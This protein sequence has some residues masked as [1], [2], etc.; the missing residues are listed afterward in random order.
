MWHKA[1]PAVG[2]ALFGVSLWVLARELDRIGFAGL[3]TSLAATPRAALL[4]ALAVTALN[5]FV[6]T[7]HDQLAFVYARVRLHRARIALAS[8][9]GY[10]VANNVGFALLSGASARYRFYSRWGVTPGELSRIVTFYSTTFWLGLC[11]MGGSSLVFARDAALAAIL[12]PF[13]TTGLGVL[14]LAVVG[15]YLIVCVRDAGPLR[16][17]GL[18]IA[19]P[20]RRLV[21]AQVLVSTLDWLLAAGVLYVLLPAPRPSLLLVTGAFAAAQ[22]VALASHVPG[23]L[24]VFEGVML[25]LLGDDVGTAP[26]ATA[27]LLFRVIYYLVPLVAAIIALLV[28]EGRQRRRQLT[29]WGATCEAVAS[30]AAPRILAVLTFASG[31][32]LLFSGA[33][34]E[35]PSRLS[36]LSEVLPLPLVELSHFAGSLTGLLLLLLAQAIL[37]R[38]DAALYVTA[39]ALAFGAVASLTK[40]GDYEEASILAAVLVALIAARRHFT[41]RAR[42]FEDP[43]SPSWFAAVATAVAASVWLGLFAYRH[44]DYTSDLW[45]RFAIDA[46]APRFLRASVAVTIG[47]LLYAVRHMLRPALP[48][49]HGIDLSSTTDLDRVIALQPKTLPYLVYLGDKSVLWNEHRTAFLMYAV[50]GRSCVALGDP[51]GPPAASRDLIDRFLRMCHESALT[52][53]FYEAS[54]D[55]L[56]D[57]ADYGMTAVKVGEEARVHLPGYSLSGSANKALRSSLNRVEREGYTFRVADPAEVRSLMPQLQE[58][59]DEWLLRKGASEKG[60][61]LGYFDEQYLARFPL[62]VMEHEG[63]V[64][65]FAN[66]WPGPGRV[67]IAADLMRYRGT[68]P[69]GV[70]DVLFV[71]MMMWARD[72]GYEWFNIGMAPLSGIPSSPVGHAWTRLGH[73]VYRNGEAFY[74]F[75][76]LRAYKEKFHPDWEPRYLAYPGGLSL[77]RVVADITALIAGGYRRIFLRYSRRA[78]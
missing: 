23:G 61:S 52:P 34:P 56:S 55:R 36:W 27:L 70:M 49:R 7:C 4:A 74:N 20:G 30:W 54:G 75:Q 71:R 37:R 33:T 26:M 48:R 28:D 68:A 31:V 42:I 15:G 63:N 77:A 14:G 35:I 21:G 24:G 62:A 5:Y 69:P 19:L 22:L 18:T 9:I 8:F 3:T 29:R 40:G 25:L 10:A 51:V 45:W 41:R 64:E 17:G 13:A 76:G 73:F 44:V 50:S 67:E 11:L 1:A 72:Q 60:F 2:V 46:N 53:V 47:A 57:F 65:A 58:I 38:V 6:L 59:S 43:V 16:I 39:G 12:P 78:A 32:V 66:L